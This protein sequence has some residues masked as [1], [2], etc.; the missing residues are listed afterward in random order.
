MPWFISNMQA[1]RA[2]LFF[3]TVWLMYKIGGNSYPVKAF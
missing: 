1:Y 2:S 3:I